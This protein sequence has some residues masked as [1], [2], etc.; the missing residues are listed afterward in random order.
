MSGTYPTGYLGFQAVDFQIVTPS[1]V[2]QAVSGKSRRIAHG[3]SYYTFSIRY[4]QILNKDFGPIRAFLAKQGGP[5]DSWQ[6]VL[7]EVSYSQGAEIASIGTPVTSGT[8]A[9]GVKTCTI[10]GLGASKSQILRAG[11]FFKFANHTKV[12]MAVDDLNSNGSGVGTLNFAGALCASVPSGTGIIANAVPF[13]VIQEG[14]TQ[15]FTTGVGFTTFEFRCRE[16]W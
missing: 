11:D 16:V 4:N 7:P 14:E 1:I 9:A 2:S 8:L 13:T 15:E 12:Y 3:H 5:V 10:S 6:I